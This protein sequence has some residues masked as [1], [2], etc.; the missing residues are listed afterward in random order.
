MN[1]LGQLHKQLQNTIFAI[2]AQILCPMVVVKSD[3]A[4]PA[5]LTRRKLDGMADQHV[6]VP[7][8][9]DRVTTQGRD[10]VFTVVDVQPD[11]KTVDLQT[12]TGD[13]PVLTGVPWTSLSYMDK[14]DSR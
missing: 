7:R 10:G 14:E 8:K 12:V 11:L 3:M 2:S 5:L 1:R 13:G 6:R 4:T 9:H